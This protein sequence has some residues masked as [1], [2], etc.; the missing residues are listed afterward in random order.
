[1]FSSNVKM[2]W[3]AEYNA[4]GH[5]T[6][7]SFPWHADTLDTISDPTDCSSR[8][9]KASGNDKSTA[10]GRPI[11]VKMMHQT[12]IVIITSLWC[13][14]TTYADNVALP[15]FASRMARCCAPCSNRSISPVG[16]MLGQTGGQTDDRQMHRPCSKTLRGAV[17]IMSASLESSR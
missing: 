14:A 12:T 6:R 9:T 7:N 4:E 16:L 17:R 5:F 3:H 10:V 15:A 13:S 1:V 2:N 8:T 11:K